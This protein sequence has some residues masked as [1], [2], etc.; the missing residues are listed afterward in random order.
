MDTIKRDKDWALHVQR[1]WQAP[2]EEV[3]ERVIICFCGRGLTKWEEIATGANFMLQCGSLV[4]WVPFD[5]DK[6]LFVCPSHDV[7]LALCKWGEGDNLFVFQPWRP[8]SSA[9]CYQSLVKRRWVRVWGLPLNLWM[10]EVFEAIGKVCGGL[11]SIDQRTMD[12][13][14]LRWARLELREIDLQAIPIV[15]SVVDRGRYFPVAITIEGKISMIKTAC[16][17]DTVVTAGGGG[18]LWPVVPSVL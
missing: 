3:W 18:S 11:H 5:V 1:S 10:M 2:E 15:I 9:I 12:C 14:E 6:A 17:L 7:A 16:L 13:E 8:D 4:T